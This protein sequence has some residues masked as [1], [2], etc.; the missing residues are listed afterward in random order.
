[1]KQFAA[2]GFLV[3]AMTAMPG[4]VATKYDYLAKGNKAFAAGKFEDASLNFRKAIQKDV[5]FGEAYYRFGLTAI[6]LEQARVAY[7]ALFRAAQL[8][9]K[10]TTVKEKFA[11]VCLGFYLADSSRPQMLYSQI[12]KLADE[13]LRKNANSYEGLILKA[14]LAVT[15]GKLTD[16]IEFF[17]RALEIDASNAGVVTE[18]AQ[19]LIRDGQAQEAEQL[20]MDLIARQQT[21]YGPAYDLLYDFY[22]KAGRVREAEDVLKIKVN[23]NPA[24]ADYILQLARHYYRFQK[25]AETQSTLRR[26]LDDPKSFPKATLFAGDFYLGIRDYEKALHYYEQGL[27]ANPEANVKEVYE[28]R[29]VAALLGQ[30]KKEEATH[31]AEQVIKENPNNLEAVRLHA[32]ILLDSGKSE[33]ADLVIREVQSVVN[34][35]PNDALLRLQLGRAFRLKGDLKAAHDQFLEAIKNQK[36]LIPVRY[37]LAEVSLLQQQPYEA[38]RHTNEILSLRSDDRRARLLRTR[39]LIGT[40]DAAT[41]RAELLGLIKKAPQDIEPHLQ[42]GFLALAEHQY[43]EAIDILS[44]QRA[45]GDQRAFAGLATAYL[46]QKRVDAARETLNE[47]L[48]R[49]PNSPVLLQQ[50]AETEALAGNYDLAVEYFQKLLSADPKSI[51]LT[52][53]LAEVYDLKGDRSNALSYSQQAN[54]L[55][56]TDL[57]VSLTLAEALTRAGRTEEARVQYLRVAKAH[58]DNAPALNNAAF[59]LADSG[60][61]LDEALQLAQRALEKVPGQPGFSDTI[62]YIYLKKGLYDSAI[63]TF[64]NL[65]RKYPMFA[66]FRYHLGLALYEK[67]DKAEARR[68]LEGALA[69]HPSGEDNLR[70]RELLAKIS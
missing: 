9:P 43:R 12:T 42:L 33:N 5:N 55:A 53:Q 64:R 6:K 20:A 62:G 47:G 22:I 66:V 57:A 32:G 29:K 27:Q 37:E 63:Q 70:I 35:R 21:S 3:A 23:N 31:L 30:G 68:E 59:F 60:G 56:P 38:L 54:A 40:G 11:D 65:T 13:L 14:Y 50:L 7:E 49:A 1:M 58:S 67:G 36:D 45:S 19:V 51:N 44:Q 52:R 16:A 4:C 69:A 18:L 25:S 2:F 48:Q 39:A 8:E 17:H 28:I 10:N 15:D 41:A 24:S 61:D 34:Q 46:R 26:L